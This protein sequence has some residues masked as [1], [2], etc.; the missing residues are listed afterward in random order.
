[1][2]SRQILTALFRTTT[3]SPRV[4]PYTIK[5]QAVRRDAILTVV[6][7]L[8]FTE[9]FLHKGLIAVHIR[10]DDRIAHKISLFVDKQG[11]GDTDH[12]L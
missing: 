8:L 2:H 3:A 7:I 5:A 4:K 1:M 12:I 9:I 6:F 10:S 11:G